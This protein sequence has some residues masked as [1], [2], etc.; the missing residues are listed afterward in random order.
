MYFIETRL[1]DGSTVQ[2][3][4][5]LDLSKSVH[6]VVGYDKLIGERLRLKVEG[7][8]QYLYDAGVEQ[9]SSSFSL[10]NAGADFCFPDND[11]LVN[12]GTGR[13]MG[14]ELTVER[15]LNKGWYLLN[16]ISVYDARYTASDNIERNTAFNGN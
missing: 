1:P 16:T 4:R 8:Y 6:A 9:R 15:Y 14:V 3:N 12:E 2:T 10:L 5:D 13:N 7:Y 11:S